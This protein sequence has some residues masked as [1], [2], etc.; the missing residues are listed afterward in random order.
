MQMHETAE[1]EALLALPDDEIAPPPPLHEAPC[2]GPRTDAACDPLT[3]ALRH[4][5]RP[6]KHV[7]TLFGLHETVLDEDMDGAVLRLNRIPGNMTVPVH[8]HVGIEMIQ[9]LEGGFTDLG[10]AYGPGDFCTV[11]PLQPHAPRTDPEGC[12]CVSYTHGRLNFLRL[13]PR[14][15]GTLIRL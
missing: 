5:R 7:R 4:G 6:S 10:R 8:T 1:A 12:V 11:A 2:N 3:H 13:L 9:V 15:I 14:L